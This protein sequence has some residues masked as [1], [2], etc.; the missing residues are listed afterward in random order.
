M[1]LVLVTYVVVLSFVFPGY[2]D[3]LYAIHSDVYFG[4]GLTIRNSSL[5][6]YFEWPRPMGYLAA[7]LIGLANVQG[8]ILVLIGVTVVSTAW[9]VKLVQCIIQRPIPVT[10]VVLYVALLFSHQHL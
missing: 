10:V 6:S 5:I 2:F 4:P 8:F 7:H 9:T 1:L 3:P